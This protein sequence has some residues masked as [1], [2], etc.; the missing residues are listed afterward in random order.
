LKGKLVSFEISLTTFSSNPLRVF[1]PV[2]RVINSKKTVT[3]VTLSKLKKKKAEG[4]PHGGAADG[5]VLQ[6]GE[7]IAD[8]V[9][10]PRD[11]L[12]VA[13]ELLSQRERD[14]VL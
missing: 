7:G 5:E 8:A 9:D 10:A 6:A 14:G 1:R 11:L 13:R 2:L 3:N 4:V 12:H